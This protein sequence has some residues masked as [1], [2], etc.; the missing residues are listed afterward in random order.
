MTASRGRDH[1]GDKHSELYQTGAKLFERDVE[2]PDREYGEA[3]NRGRRAD[4]GSAA[5]PGFRQERPVPRQHRGGVFAKGA[6]VH[7]HADFS[8]GA[9]RWRIRSVTTSMIDT[10]TM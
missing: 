8:T 7:G 6:A 3:D 2:P 10:A 9:S 5:I 1:Q 4:F